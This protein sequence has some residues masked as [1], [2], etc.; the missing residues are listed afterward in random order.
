MIMQ[1]CYVAREETRDNIEQAEFAA[2]KERP[3]YRPFA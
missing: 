1:R 2:V 3:R